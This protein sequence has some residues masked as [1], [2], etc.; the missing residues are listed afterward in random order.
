MKKAK[1]AKK[2]SR[3][4]KKL[5]ATKKAR[6]TKK[7]HASKKSHR[8]KKAQV[9]KRAPDRKK[10]GTYPPIV[11]C[12]GGTIEHTDGAI[13][14]INNFTAP[15][16]ITSC[17]VPCWPSPPAPNPV[18]PAAQNGVAGEKTVALV[19]IPQTGTYSYTASCCPDAVPP[20][21]IVV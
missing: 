5:H 4:A 7:S 13:T 14:F 3:S 2:K 21:I 20:K 18:V 17:T 15:C 16:T 12:D 10:A 11:L 9:T 6:A 1:K 8:T 19:C